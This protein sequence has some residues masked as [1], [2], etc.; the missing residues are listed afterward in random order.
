[1]SPA[2]VCVRHVIG[3]GSRVTIEAL[4]DRC[5]PSGVLVCHCYQSRSNTGRSNREMRRTQCLSL[6]LSLCC[7]FL[8]GTLHALQDSGFMC[9]RSQP[10]CVTSHLKT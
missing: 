2:E 9:T 4:C 7:S 1:M 5:L 8:V 6:K 10:G 3:V